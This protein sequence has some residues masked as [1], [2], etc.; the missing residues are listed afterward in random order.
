MP[1]LQTSELKLD[2]HAYE[3]YLHKLAKANDPNKVTVESTNAFTDTPLFRQYIAD[4]KTS[5]AFYAT[6]PF[7]KKPELLPQMERPTRDSCEEHHLAFDSTEVRR[8]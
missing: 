6:L 4:C 5:D 1:K 7:P 2:L 8:I 3:L